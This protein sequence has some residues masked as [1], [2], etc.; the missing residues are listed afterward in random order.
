MD[1]K[2]IVVKPVSHPSIGGMG[3]VILF[4]DNIRTFKL[5]KLPSEIGRPPLK[6]VVLRSRVVKALIYPNHIGMEPGKRKQEVFKV[7]RNV[8]YHKPSIVN[9]GFHDP[10]TILLNPD[11][12][13]D[14][15]CPS[16]HVIHFHTS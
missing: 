1:Y 7:S 10:I 12:F 16:L 15:T 6:E 9:C 4:H 13:I 8:R 11:K 3:P 5:Y 14:I 2:F